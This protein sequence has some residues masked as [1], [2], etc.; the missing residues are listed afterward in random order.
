MKMKSPEEIL[1]KAD[2]MI[3]QGERSEPE[4]LLKRFVADTPPDWKPVCETP[5]SIEIAY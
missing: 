5:Y 1:N 4:R 3:Q 2:L